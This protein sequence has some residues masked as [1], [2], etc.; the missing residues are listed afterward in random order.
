MA[1]VAANP[2]QVKSPPSLPAQ[3][4][5]PASMKGTDKA[6]VIPSALADPSL[7]TRGKSGWPVRSRTGNP[8]IAATSS[9][10]ARQAAKMPVNAAKETAIPR[11]E[12]PC[13]STVR[14]SMNAS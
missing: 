2:V 12:S 10:M 11:Y 5:T 4:H 7:A 9:R 6:H 1:A 13:R 3:I 8:R 14:F